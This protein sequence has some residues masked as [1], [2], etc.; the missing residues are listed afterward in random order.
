MT[1]TINGEERTIGGEGMS[2]A[3]LAAHLGLEGRIAMER[4]GMILKRDEWENE[5]LEQGDTIEIVQ[6]V[7]GG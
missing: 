2:A 1:L 7:G 6:F 5:T 3:D 4:N